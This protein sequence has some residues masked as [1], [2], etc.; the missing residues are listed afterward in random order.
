MDSLMMANTIFTGLLFVAWKRSD[1]F[2]LGI[3][4]A[5]LTIF[6]LNILRMVGKV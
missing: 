1:M 5:I 4:V 3:K 2:N 6:V